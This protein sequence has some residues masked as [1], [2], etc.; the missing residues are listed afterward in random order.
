MLTLNLKQEENN[1]QILKS[2]KVKDFIMLNVGLIMT[3]FCLVMIFEPNNAVFGGVGGIGIILDDIIPVPVSVIV[4]VINAILLIVGWIF[5]GKEFFLKTLYGSLA[6][7]VYAFL[8][9]L[10]FNLFDK[11]IIII[12][13][14]SLIKSVVVKKSRR[15]FGVR[16]PKAPSGRELPTKSGEGERVTMKLVQI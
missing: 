3:A 6:Y 11:N 15:T 10:L 1:M 8:L 13:L 9:E 16:K 12:A 2:R 4:F 5:I 7:P 14:V